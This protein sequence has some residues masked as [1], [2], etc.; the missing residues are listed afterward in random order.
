MRTSAPT[1]QR[2]F[3][4]LAP[5]ATGASGASTAKGRSFKDTLRELAL[6]AQRERG[7]S[8]ARK[9]QQGEGPRSH[10]A[11]Q[12]PGSKGTSEPADARARRTDHAESRGSPPLQSGQGKD[13]DDAEA[14]VAAGSPTGA[15][16]PGRSVHGEGSSDAGT[17]LDERTDS[18]GL[19]GMTESAASAPA[20]SGEQGSVEGQSAGSVVQGRSPGTVVQDVGPASSAQQRLAAPVHVEGQPM[21]IVDLNRLLLRVGVR[22]PGTTDTPPGLD[23]RLGAAPQRGSTP[24]LREVQATL[25]TGQQHG[26]SDFRALESALAARPFGGD[27]T[28]PLQGSEQI[29]ARESMPRATT[30]EHSG[31]PEPGEESPR[32]I[33]AA[34]YRPNEPRNGHGWRDGVS[35]LLTEPRRPGHDSS[36]P[37]PTAERSTKSFAVSQAGAGDSGAGGVRGR[38]AAS[39]ER[40]SR[41]SEAQDTSLR[42]QV[43]R[44]VMAAANQRGGSVVVRLQPETLGQLRVH[45]DSSRGSLA[46]RL[47]V[48][49]EQ[50]RGLLRQSMGELRAALAERGLNVDQP[51]IRLDPILAQEKSSGSVFGPWQERAADESDPWNGRKGSDR[52]SEEQP[53]RAF[54]DGVERRTSSHESQEADHIIR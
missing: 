23:Q 53:S 38:A 14:A 11:D 33:G 15:S 19:S 41:G 10:I 39:S 17:P 32:D 12:I 21:T 34:R 51:Q 9:P 24:M 29:G 6:T 36:S 3:P 47:D 27:P 18:G 5:G 50:A 49:N 43:A 4:F 26:A 7:V 54:R 13:G 40:T 31:R 42:A 25:D 45:I 16:T 22:D 52:G 37:A 35:A 1:P 30:A 20:M 8:K 48:G 2:V 28:N 46:V 44:G